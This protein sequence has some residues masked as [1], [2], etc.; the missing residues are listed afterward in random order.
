MANVVGILVQ[1]CLGSVFT[2][3]LWRMVRT[4]SY[5]TVSLDDMFSMRSNPLAM[6]RA[7]FKLEA[8]ILIMLSLFIM[9]TSIAV[10]F[11]PGAITVK[12][13]TSITNMTVPSYGIFNVSIITSMLGDCFADIASYDC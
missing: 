10:S 5:T 9:L 12:R 13:D 8:G 4:T 2:Q 3:Y 1:V 6:C 7:L 11:P